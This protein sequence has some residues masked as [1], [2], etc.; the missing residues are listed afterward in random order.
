MILRLGEGSIFLDADRLLLIGSHVSID[1]LFLALDEDL[2]LL[3]RVL[4]P[5]ELIV[6]LLE[7]LLLIVRIGFSDTVL[8]K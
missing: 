5:E 6:V 4:F 2:R 8:G 3:G 1:D 7:R